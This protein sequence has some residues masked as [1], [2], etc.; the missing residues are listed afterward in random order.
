MF[1]LRWHGRWPVSKRWSIVFQ[2]MKE[3]KH[4][5]LLLWSIWTSQEEGL[6]FSFM[7]VVGVSRL[8]TWLS[9][10]SSCGAE[11]A[12]LCDCARDYRSRT[13]KRVIERKKWWSR[14]EDTGTVLLGVVERREGWWERRG[15]EHGHGVVVV[16]LATNSLAAFRARR[17][18]QK[19]RFPPRTPLR[20]PGVVLSKIAFQLHIKRFL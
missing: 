12:H 13:E 10:A 20:H 16:C 6:S 9:T 7:L 17:A 3:E 1:T 14:A 4:I 2:H 8:W 5:Y 18:H 19:S 11:R 15:L